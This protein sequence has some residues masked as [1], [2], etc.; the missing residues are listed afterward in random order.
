SRMKKKLLVDVDC[1]VDDAQAIMLALAAPNVELLGI[2][3]VHGN[4]TVE[5]V[6]K[7]TLR[8]LQACNRL[9]IPVFK[10]AAKPLLGNTISAGHFHGYDGLGDAPDPNAPGLDMVQEEAAV[11]AMLRIINENPGEVSLV[12]TAP[13]TNLALAVRMDPSFPSKLRGLYI[14]GGNTESRGN[15][16]VC[17]EFNFT[18]DP[19]AAYVVLRD[20]GCPTYLACWEFTCSSKLSWEFCDA[21]LAQDTDKAR[22]MAKIFQHSMDAS[23]SSRFQKEFVGGSGFISCD[24]YAMAAAVDDSFVLESTCYPVS[25]ELTGTHTRGMMVLDTVGFLKTAS[26]VFIINKVDMQKFEQMM[27]AALK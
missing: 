27:M 17:G 11:S 19:E 8:V 15:T 6:C 9:E 1:G 23:K 24:S 5:N 18:A 13:L 25:V 21:W 14:M 2:T 3:C 16:T 7:N 4:T 20:Y 22:F 10:G 26:K 12:A